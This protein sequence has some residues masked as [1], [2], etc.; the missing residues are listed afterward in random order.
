MSVSPRYTLSDQLSYGSLLLFRCY[1]YIF[2]SDNI[3][4]RPTFEKRAVHSG[5]RN[6]SS[7]YIH[8]G[9]R[10]LN[11]IVSINGHCIPVR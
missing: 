5:K 6:L 9:G 7:S 10:I 11:P 3:A 4:V 8:F 1:I 2:M